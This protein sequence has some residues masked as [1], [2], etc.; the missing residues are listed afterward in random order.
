VLLRTLKFGLFFVIVMCSSANAVDLTIVS[1]EANGCVASQ[2][3]TIQ[4][5][6][7]QP[8]DVAESDVIVAVEISN[9]S[10]FSTAI[11]IAA[12]SCGSQQCQRAVD[13]TGQELVDEN[14]HPVYS[15][16]L[17][18]RSISE[19]DF[20]FSDLEQ[21]QFSFGYD[22]V[23]DGNVV[24]SITLKYNCFDDGGNIY[25]FLADECA[26]LTP[27]PSPPALL[28]FVLDRRP[29]DVEFTPGE[30][31]TILNSTNTC[32][33]NNDVI[34]PTV[35][36]ASSDVILS[37]V[38]DT[39]EGCSL[40]RIFR[41]EDSCGNRVE[42]VW[43]QFS[44]PGQGDVEISLD[45]YVC[46]DANCIADP[47][48][49]TPF[50]SGTAVI[51]AQV[52]VNI[53]APA[54]CVT[55]QSSALYISDEQGAFPT[56]CAET[57]E[58]CLTL[59]SGD[60]ITTPGLY[61]A[62]VVVGACGNT[63]KTETLEFEVLNKPQLN[64]G[65]PYLI[66]EGD[67]LVLDASG[68]S[69][70]D[71]AAFG[72]IVSYEW[73]LDGDDQF[74]PELGVDQV[75]A[76]VVF[77]TE[78]DGIFPIGLRITTSTGIVA[79]LPGDCVRA[80]G[81]NVECETDCRALG[82]VEV[83]DVGPSCSLGG[84]FQAFDG[85]T[86]TFDQTAASP[87]HPS[88]AISSY[89]WDFGDGFTQNAFDLPNPSHVYG[90][91]GDAE[92]SFTVTL[93]LL[94]EDNSSATCSTTVTIQDATPII[95]ALAVAPDQELMEGIAITFVAATA[96]GSANDPIIN[97][98]WTFGDGQS[99]EGEATREVQH[100]YEQSGDYE[101][102][103]TVSDSDSSAADCININIGEV[104]PIPAFE[105][106]AEGLVQGQ[107]GTFDAQDSV[108]GGLTDPIERY[109]WKFTS[110]DNPN[111]APDFLQS[112]GALTSVTYTFKSDGRYLIELT[113]WDTD[114]SATTSREVMVAD[115]VPTAGIRAF[116]SRPEETVDEGE[117]ITLGAGT[118][119]AG[120]E[121][122][123]IVQYI[124]NFGDGNQII[125]NPDAEGRMPTGQNYAW[126]DEGNG[127]YIVELIVVDSDGSRA[128]AQTQVSVLN[129]APE[130]QLYTTEERIELG[131]ALQ[132]A[133]LHESEETEFNSPTVVA[134]VED[135]FADFLTTEA[136][137]T[138]DGIE[139]N[140]TIPMTFDSMGEKVIRCAISDGDGGADETATTITVTPAAPQFETIAVQNGIEGEM[141]TFSLRVN[142]PVVGVDMYGDVAL[143][144]L[145]KPGGA[146]VTTNEQS[147]GVVINFEWTPGFYD[148][149]VHRL[150]LRA[151]QGDSSRERTVDIQISDNGRPL[152][153]ALGGSSARGTVSLFEF[154]EV[155]GD[156]A[157]EATDQ[158]IEIGLGAG[159]MVHNP[160]SGY[161]FV[162][163]PGSNRVA[164][165]DL[166]GNGSLVRRIP[167]G[168]QPTGIVS[169]G[170]KV[171]VVSHGD[172][173]IAAIDPNTLKVVATV[174]LNGLE[175]PTD[176]VW[177][178]DG[179][180]GLEGAHIAVVA[181]GNGSV[182]L[183]DPERVM[184]FVT[185]V[186]YSVQIGGLLTNIEA[187]PTTNSLEISDET[188]R[189]I[190]S[191]AP[192]DLTEGFDG[193]S[194]QSYAITFAARDLLVRDGV[195]W[196]AQ[197]DALLNITNDGID[198]LDFTSGSVLSSVATEITSE[199]LMLLFG[200]NRI[201][202]YEVNEDLSLELKSDIPS[203]PVRKM[204]TLIAPAQ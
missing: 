167:V 96:A 54:S 121:A 86:L 176:L 114:S 137:W 149:G 34:N 164:V 31:A 128:T 199:S 92:R 184:Q 68:T 139:F 144:I 4:G 196:V 182:G 24:F 65:G 168:T 60:A 112:L 69:L 40:D 72:E 76:S 53:D 170:G 193:S 89:N 172:N 204:L 174:P 41:A 105:L 47:N 132:F 48:T 26:G 195:T 111:E 158:L 14:G 135:T 106:P 61:R 148:S 180:D 58:R 83:T 13:G 37:E 126:G 35:T 59:F 136:V 191:I 119:M 87:G 142:A 51:G 159:D 1:P 166:R 150:W 101:V 32:N 179:F 63:V 116:Y 125:Q 45:G 5:I 186:E 198:V 30:I 190:Y 38:V 62:E 93:E 79:E 120:A 12:H 20:L 124:W 75:G 27:E 162:T 169:G 39:Q 6:A 88:D 23:Q 175:N 141:L 153:V 67:N 15:N 129:V 82:V 103:L 99:G 108:A 147:D 140:P 110:L 91:Q 44:P 10:F 46:T 178:D 16:A 64:F 49:M 55:Q 84:P 113:V 94:D 131:Q 70:P 200:S 98:Q 155:D 25:P 7:G 102:C 202:V 33:I 95:S 151:G 2:Q 201:K 9:W 28:P 171:W 74:E 187:N 29:P 104:S 185:P 100:M 130:V 143:D 109:N 80:C 18:S 85:E 19:S 56:D 177:L 154:N 21:R 71:D 157:L 3:G 77:D 11:S 115:A 145:E 42:Y 165:I 118:S 122:D 8:V 66:A 78:D 127:T 57:P 203:S 133:M 90:F 183:V 52:L 81:A 107:S 181:S 161:L 97:H 73:D 152:A 138:V 117:S 163:V 17:L 36:D 134:R 197:G 189:R 194:S 192:S 22:K 173:S 123:P 50:A 146:R 156:V 188:T 160:D 43:S